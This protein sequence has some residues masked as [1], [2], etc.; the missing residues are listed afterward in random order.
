VAVLESSK[1]ALDRAMKGALWVKPELQLRPQEDR[2]AR[3]TTRLL[4]EAS[5]MHY[6]KPSKDNGHTGY[7]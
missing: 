3:S 7:N 5:S 6:I 1:A 2:N 4:R